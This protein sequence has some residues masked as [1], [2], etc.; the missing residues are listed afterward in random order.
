MLHPF[1][2]FSLRKL[3]PALIKFTL[4]GAFLGNF[5]ACHKGGEKV[6]SAS[7]ASTT[8][9][10]AST[11]SSAAAL[12]PVLQ[13]MTEDL[14]QVKSNAL[15]HGPVVT[16]VIQPERRADLRAEVASVVLQVLKENGDAVK[17][18]ELLLRLD[19][20][21]MRDSL[22][23]AQEA[24][25]AAQSLLQQAERQLERQK[26]LRA[27]G[28]TSTAALEDSQIRVNTANNE[29]ISAKAREVQARQQLQHAEVRAPFDGLVSE[30]KASVGDTA[31]IGKELMK[32]IDPAS[33]RFEGLVAADQ[34]V[35]LKLGQAVFFNVNGYGKQEF[36]GRIK[37]I[38]PSANLAT[39]QVAVQI[40]F[41]GGQ[42]PKVAG[43]F[44]EG[45]I[46]TTT[47]ASLTVP[48]VS[49]QRVGDKT[50]VWRFDGKKI[51]KVEVMLG[52]RDTRHGDFAVSQGVQSGDALLRNPNSS[53]IDGQV[54][55]KVDS[56][57]IPAA[58]GSAASTAA[59]SAASHTK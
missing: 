30:R 27:S 38:D 14:Y 8:A 20:T 31:Q 3:V 23:A 46:E 26:T 17:R 6:A 13:V 12:A 55:K 41:D 47:V 34:I 1:V 50:F 57:I 29:L 53:L 36:L 39:R 52:E 37:R 43:L 42:Q 54:A 9:S 4:L 59:N 7:A 18:G 19:E 28:M 11:T 45:R 51:N 49:L 56:K 24:V 25:R 15:A 35:E 40:A 44:A 16:G 33:M 2:P 22:H 58:V 48:E 10:A 32:V 5:A 21:A